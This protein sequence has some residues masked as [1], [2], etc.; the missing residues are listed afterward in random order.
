MDW[1][2]LPRSPKE[3]VASVGRFGHRWMTRQTEL[4]LCA[5]GFSLTSHALFVKAHLQ[6]ACTFAST[7]LLST[8][9]FHDGGMDFH[10][11]KPLH[12]PWKVPLLMPKPV[13]K[14]SAKTL[15]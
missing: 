2:S 11:R 12:R 13:F 4:R 9:G 10:L 14:H 3:D 8:M 1:L 5:I 6:T 7:I 15:L